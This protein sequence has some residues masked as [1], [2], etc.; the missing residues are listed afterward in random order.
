MGSEQRTAT[1]K[2]PPQFPGL[3]ARCGR[4]SEA[5]GDVLTI[6]AASFSLLLLA[7]LM[8]PTGARAAP[9]PLRIV[10]INLLHGGMT[11]ELA[12]RDQ[13]LEERLTMV[14]REL[15]TL[16]ADVVGVQEASRGRRRGDVAARLASALGFHHVY[17]QAAPRW[18][19]VSRVLGLEEGPAVLSRFP[20]VTSHAYPID[21][22]GGLYRRGLVCAELATPRGPLEACSTHLDGSDCHA[23]RVASILGARPRTAPLLL[24]GDLNATEQSKGIRNLI[25]ALGLVDTFRAANPAAPGFTVWQ[26]V[27]LERPFASRRV[28]FILLAP[29]ARRAGCSGHRTTTG[30]CPRWRFSGARVMGRQG[31][32]G[33]EPELHDVQPPSTAPDFLG[34]R[35][36]LTRPGVQKGSGMSQG[37]DGR[38]SPSATSTPARAAPPTARTLIGDTTR[39][40]ARARR[41]C[42]RIAAL[43]RLN[44][45]SRNRSTSVAIPRPIAVASRVGDR[46]WWAS[47][48]C[49]LARANRADDFDADGNAVDVGR[50]LDARI[51]RL[52]Q[53]DLDGVVPRH[54]GDPDANNLSDGLEPP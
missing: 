26:P 38:G 37:K 5:T 6:P 54:A 34:H 46:V 15:R 39:S 3:T 14:V 9:R 36:G 20:I 30:C 41:A 29:G 16:D 44:A 4:V 43:R 49:V 25:A 12:G 17:A 22:C 48:P 35:F 40:T 21:G 50:Q 13:H 23:E 24:M 7:S 53:V 32:V 1:F 11:S 8:I 10:T 31:P 18:P 28:D 2:R 45:A 19:L 51:D 52:A 42:R 47:S 33:R 27:W